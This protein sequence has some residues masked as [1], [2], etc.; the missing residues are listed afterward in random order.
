MSRTDDGVGQ[1][2]AGL[3]KLLCALI[4]AV[5]CVG[6][7]A[8]YWDQV[9]PFYPIKDWLF[10]NVGAIWGWCLLFNLGCLCFGHLALTRWLELGELPVLEKLVS[11][12]VVGL[13][14]FVIAMYVGGALRIYNAWFAVA[15]PLLMIALGA[16]GIVTFARRA[17]LEMSWEARR[18][19]P[20]AVA[21]C[22]AGVLCVGLVYLQCMT[23]VSLNYDARWY[24]LT[25]AQDY[26]RAGRMMPFLAEYTKAFPHLASIVHTWGFLVPG[27]N[28]PERWMMILHQEFGIFLWTLAGVGAATSWLVQRPHA[29]S[30]WAA[31]FLFPI[32]FVSDSNLGGAAD[33]FLAFFACPLFLAAVRAGG[34]LA[35]KY[36]ALVAVT[37]AGALLTKYQSIY[38]IVPSGIWIVGRFLWLLAPRKAALRPARIWRGPLTLLAV[39]V[40]LA[41]PHFIKNWIFYGNP[42]FP[43]MTDAFAGTWPRRAESA[44]LIT[45]LFAD[46]TFEPKDKWDALKTAFNFSFVPH[47][48]A[49]KPKMGSLFTLLLPTLPFLRQKRLWIGALL[50]MGAVLTWSF[51]YLVDRYAQ[52]FVPLLAAVTC[53]MIIRIW[54]LGF[55]ARLGL[56][57]LVVFQ[58]IWGGD[59]LFY[60]GYGR[61]NDAFNLIRSGHEGKAKTRFD[62]YF[63]SQLALDQRLPPDAVILLHNTRLTLGISRTTYSDI[64]GFQ[65][66]ISYRRIRTPRELFQLYRFL[67]ITH[68]IHERGVY[69][70]FT[71]QEEAVFATFLAR[72]TRNSFRQGEYEVF[73]LP[74]ES[75][76]LEPSYRVLSLGISG[77]GNGIYPV[78][79]MNTVDPMQARFRKYP[80]PATP[81]EPEAAALPGLLEKD[82]DVVFV[83][84]STSIPE[85][86][87]PVLSA[88]F[89]RLLTYNHQ[90]SVHVRL[91]PRVPPPG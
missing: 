85:G 56:V 83:G 49:P 51:T 66:L 34:L 3:G 32:I 67:G 13:V 62:S 42:M 40:L 18:P 9:E 70:S 39:G 63:P 22:I 36:C 19:S 71:K 14:A 21:A 64:P 78:E 15:L 37:A 10:W 17:T 12:M 30:S 90:F 35:P 29:R 59:A 91:T 24:H 88:Q 74:V 46:D 72:Y 86:L 87:A 31:F 11:S 33:H 61:M 69:P 55:V 8:L 54:E 26:A 45:H 1:V 75:P 47:Y 89:E 60:D 52:A 76:P 79:A 77:Y 50:G 38:L 16:R 57:P 4:V 44:E 65:G 48:N 25:V 7:V 20:L 58:V 53:A 84:A 81:I 28:Q 6:G 82:V 41:S 43:F 5:I 80:A 27:L 23:P 2:G 68:V 73:E